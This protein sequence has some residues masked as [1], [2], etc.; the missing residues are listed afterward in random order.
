M[1]HFEAMQGQPQ[2]RDGPFNSE[3]WIRKPVMIQEQD[4]SNHHTSKKTFKPHQIKVFAHSRSPIQVTNQIVVAA[5]KKYIT[6]SG[7]VDGSLPVRA[8]LQKSILITKST[9]TGVEDWEVNFTDT[10][11]MMLKDSQSMIELQ[12]NIPD[13]GKFLLSNF[14][15]LMES[16]VKMQ[17]LLYKFKLT[18]SKIPPIFA[19][20]ISPVVRRVECALRPGVT[21]LQW[22]SAN[23][24]D[25][26]MNVKR[27]IENLEFVI[28]K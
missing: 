17:E 3:P 15:R 1:S 27:T 11:Y 25:Y 28:Q 4:T 13:E 19:P 21:Y 23:I 5:R 7:K 20:L 18:I 6:D 12:L 26:I 22:L 14:N 9:E 8:K 10:L 16:K 24:D 2:R